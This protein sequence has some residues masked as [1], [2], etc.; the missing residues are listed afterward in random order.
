MRFG[1]WVRL[2][3]AADEMSEEPGVFQLRLERGLVAY[4]RGRSAMILYGAGRS[5]RAAV[6]EVAAAHPG[7]PWLARAAVGPVADP[8]AA[9]AG[10]IADFAARFGA[11]PH[12]PE[13]PD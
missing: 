4:P 11:A 13:E 10:L 3:E 5:L 1:R 12:L 8:E 9:L 7:A 2:A 6:A